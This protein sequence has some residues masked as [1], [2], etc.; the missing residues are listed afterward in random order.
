MGGLKKQGMSARLSATP[1][2]RRLSP[3]SHHY[4]APWLNSRSAII[5]SQQV[6]EGTGLMC[7]DRWLLEA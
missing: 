7:I 1:V 4:S 6:T 5:S 3:H 2:S